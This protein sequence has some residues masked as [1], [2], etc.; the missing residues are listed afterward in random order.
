MNEYTDTK[1]DESLEETKLYINKMNNGIDEDKWIIWAIEHR[2]SK[3]V[4]GTISIWNINLEERNAEL[5]Y[6]IAVS[7]QNKGLMKE[8]LLSIIDYG[9]NCINLNSLEAYTEENNINSI[10]L[11]EKCK[12]IE[13]GRVDDEGLYSDRIYHMIVY[14]L[15]INSY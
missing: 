12:F 4:I 9:F 6:G 8:A 3:K 11:L 13:V 14:K 1:L 15:N 7:H 2:Q 10:K 5:A